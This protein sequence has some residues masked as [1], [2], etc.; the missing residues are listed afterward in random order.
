MKKMFWGLIFICLNLNLHQYIAVCPNFDLLPD[1]IGYFL[2]L[3]GVKELGPRSPR[4][5]K[6]TGI[7]IFCLVVS[8]AEFILAMMESIGVI[9]SLLSFAVVIMQLYI[10]YQVARAYEEIESVSQQGIQMHKCWNMRLYLFLILWL[11]TLVIGLMA[12]VSFASGG[13]TAIAGIGLVVILGLGLA[14][15]CYGISYLVAAYRATN[16]YVPDEVVRIETENEEER[17]DP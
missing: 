17:H 12:G 8:A 16:E 7:L 3:L 13:G 2:L 9:I 6:M 14:S 15:F 4:L 5:E 1:F 11:C 10:L